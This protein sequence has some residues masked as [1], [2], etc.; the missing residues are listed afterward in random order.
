MWCL[1][2][3]NIATISNLDWHLVWS[4]VWHS[5]IHEKWSE[6]ST[7][8]Y[9]KYNLKPQKSPKAEASESRSVIQ[10]FLQSRWYWS[11]LAWQNLRSWFPKV[12]SGAVPLLFQHFSRW[13]QINLPHLHDVARTYY[14]HL[15]YCWSVGIVL[16][17]YQI[18]ERTQI[19]IIT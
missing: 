16:T 3:A 13:N 7:F 18:Q 4:S 8:F 6:I 10:T 11:A 2:S 17:W 12:A 19:W 9:V 1:Q 5:G 14:F 15:I